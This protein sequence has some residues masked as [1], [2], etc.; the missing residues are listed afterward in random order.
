M[1]KMFCYHLFASRETCSLQKLLEYM[2]Q[3]AGVSE[4]DKSKKAKLR[5]M[6]PTK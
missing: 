6:F 1:R 2:Q 3:W 5:K 4:E